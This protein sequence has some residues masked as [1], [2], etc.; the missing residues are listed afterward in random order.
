MGQVIPLTSRPARAMTVADLIDRITRVRDHLPEQCRDDLA[1]LDPICARVA[2]DL[3]GRYS[4]DGAY[5][6][7]TFRRRP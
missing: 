2:T 1:T 3:G 6:V 5:L 7:F 4:R